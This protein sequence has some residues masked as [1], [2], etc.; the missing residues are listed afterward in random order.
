MDSAQQYRNAVL[1]S[2]NIDP[3][4]ISTEKSHY[5]Q[6][7]ITKL[8]DKE[9]PNS[10]SLLSAFSRKIRHRSIS[11]KTI[12]LVIIFANAC[13]YI[14]TMILNSRYFRRKPS[15]HRGP[16]YKHNKRPEN[17]SDWKILGFANQA[18]LT[19]AKIWYRQLENL[20]YNEHFIVALD[21]SVFEELKNSSYRVLGAPKSGRYL[22]DGEGEVLK[23]EGEMYLKTIENYQKSGSNGCFFLEKVRVFFFTFLFGQSG[24]NGLAI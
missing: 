17:G 1:D 2:E 13:F 14:S 21:R 20:G 10:I 8:T 7:T 12:F 9:I 18:Y 22:D 19:P 5:V 16:W 15:G 23:Y 24:S 6:N 3:K 4:N 11:L